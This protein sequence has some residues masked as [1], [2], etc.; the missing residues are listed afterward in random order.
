MSVLSC[1]RGNCPAIMCDR[2]S[3]QFGYICAACFTE[4]VDL[5][6]DAD[7]VEFMA[8]DIRPKI[9]SREQSHKKWDGEFPE[10]D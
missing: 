6:E 7:L 4:L 5:G 8:S 10:G 9:N 1:S 3:P 2:Y